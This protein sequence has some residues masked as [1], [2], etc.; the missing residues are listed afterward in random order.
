MHLN[1]DKPLTKST[2]IK[3]TAIKKTPKNNNN[4]IVIMNYS[5]TALRITGTCLASSHYLS[6][7]VY[8]D[9]LVQER[10]NS[11]A[12][13]LELHLSCTNPSIYSLQLSMSASPIVYLTKSQHCFGQQTI[14]WTHNNHTAIMSQHTVTHGSSKLVPF[15]YNI[16]RYTMSVNINF[17]MKM[18]FIQ[19]L[20]V[21]N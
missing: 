16:A 2:V 17:R 9:E 14:T 1:Y 8:M 18:I 20:S 19:Q 11:I 4:N 21:W 15:F 6:Q 12:N 3:L 13:A 7:P 5:I 10:R